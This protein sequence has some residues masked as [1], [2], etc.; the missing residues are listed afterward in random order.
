MNKDVS[1]FLMLE[2]MG[3]IAVSFLP[4]A[5]PLS[6]LFATLYC[7]GKLSED[8]EITAMRSFGLSKRHLLMPFLILGMVISLVAFALGNN[9]IPLAKKNFKFA[10]RSLSS[11]G[12]LSEIRP[13]EFFNQIPSVTLYTE[14]VLDNGKV[15]KNVFINFF[16]NDSGIKNLIWAEKGVLI[17]ESPDKWGLADLR[18]RLFDGMMLKAD[19]SKESSEKAF[20]QE[21]DL[22]ILNTS[23]YKQ[24]NEKAEMKPLF[25]LYYLIIKNPEAGREL[26]GDKEFMKGRLEFWNR[27]NTPFICLLFIFLGFG[28]GVKRSRG[29]DRNTGTLCLIVLIVYY[30]LYFAGISMVKS[31]K[32][33]AE[34]AVVIPSLVCLFVGIHF[35]RKIDWAG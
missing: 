19:E 1:P 25:E 27:F 12:L 14:D 17:K 23:E 3:N 4:M 32:L 2:L 20:F 29:K 34:Y 11:R 7:L 6:A 24:R 28:L 18:L 30:S 26:L 22:P 16:Q 10:V 21:Y 15:L 35:Y 8:L 9:L 13:K 5:F 33:G 31:G